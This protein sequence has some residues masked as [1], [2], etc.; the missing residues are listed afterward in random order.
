[1]CLNLPLRAA[2]VASTSLDS[3]FIIIDF[4]E[5]FKFHIISML[6]HKLY[7]I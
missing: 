3:I 6:I 5:F 2:L 7:V 1:M 4:P